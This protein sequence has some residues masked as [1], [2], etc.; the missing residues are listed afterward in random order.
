MKLINKT[1]GSRLPKIPDSIFEALVREAARWIGLDPEAKVTIEIAWTR[2]QFKGWCA[3]TLVRI[4][5]PFNAS[6]GGSGEKAA[7]SA[8]QIA[9]HEMAHALD[10]VEGKRFPCDKGISSARRPA[11][12]KRPEEVSVYDRMVDRGCT[13]DRPNAWWIKHVEKYPARA[14]KAIAD[15][16]SFLEGAAR[17]PE[18]KHREGSIGWMDEQREKA[19]IAYYKIRDDEAW[20]LIARADS[21]ERLSRLEHLR[22]KKS[23]KSRADET[24]FWFTLDSRLARL[25]VEKEAKT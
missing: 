15:L 19:R 2:R 11:H 5:I 4:G 20:L 9:I 10:A 16:A 6:I 17:N 23:W 12:G 18:R 13:S 24:D 21:K 3:G 1:G 14:E 25:G 7:L 22:S 8:F